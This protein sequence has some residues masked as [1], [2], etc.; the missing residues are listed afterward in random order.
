MLEDVASFAMEQSSLIFSILANFYIF[1]ANLKYFSTR[2]CLLF[3]IPRPMFLLIFSI[4]KQFYKNG[5]FR[6]NCSKSFCFSKKEDPSNH[7]YQSYLL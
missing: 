4:Y 5:R 7:A 1:F 2:H 6:I 3:I